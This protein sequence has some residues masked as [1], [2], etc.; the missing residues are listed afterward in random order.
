MPAHSLLF[1]PSRDVAARPLVG[2]PI[3]RLVSESVQALREKRLHPGAVDVGPPPALDG[4]GVAPV[5]KQQAQ[6]LVLGQT[7][8]P[9]RPGVAVPRPA[10]PALPAQP[11]VPTPAQPGLERVVD[12]A[13]VVPGP[14]VPGPLLVPL[15]PLPPPPLPRL[16]QA[17]V[18]L[19][20]H[21][22]AYV[23]RVLVLGHGLELAAAA[24]AQRV[25][26][27]PV[28]AL[29]VRRALVV[30]HGVE[31]RLAE[32]RVRVKRRASEWVFGLGV[33]R[34]FFFPVAPSSP[35]P[36]PVAPATRLF[37]AV[38]VTSAASVPA[39]VFFVAASAGRPV[40]ARNLLG[41]LPEYESFMSLLNDCTSSSASASRDVRSDGCG[42]C[43]RVRFGDAREA[44]WGN[45]G[46]SVWYGFIEERMRARLDG[47]SEGS[48][49]MTS[50]LHEQN[51]DL[52]LIHFG[53]SHLCPPD[54][55]ANDTPELAK[56][57]ALEDGLAHL[58]A[59]VSGSLELLLPGGPLSDRQLLPRDRGPALLKGRGVSPAVGLVGSASVPSDDYVR[60]K[61]YP[62]LALAL[63]EHHG[64]VGLG[65]PL[66]EGSSLAA[67]LATR[68][69]A[70][71]NF[72]T[73]RMGLSV[74]WRISRKL[75]MMMASS[76]TPTPK[77]VN[78]V[79]GDGAFEGAATT[80]RAGCFGLMGFEAR[81]APLVD[82]VT[83]SDP[84]VANFFSGMVCTTAVF[85]TE[86]EASLTTGGRRAEE[87]GPAGVV[88]AAAAAAALAD[89]VDFGGEVLDVMRPAEVGTGG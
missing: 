72:L 74:K 34:F 49:I 58:L 20:P 3:C 60:C 52:V 67:A 31:Q 65:Q 61:F 46:P 4:P 48:C 59:P 71:A 78:T 64:P 69:L 29:P 56:E 6:R 8:V 22:G 21:L 15:R 27:L 79:L 55:I 50:R 36:V 85:A 11:P 76:K 28:H 9:A 43:G 13:G 77:M 82:V 33:W 73:P 30:R 16:Q 41:L 54:K 38:V 42:S 88:V 17:R 10:L 66:Q 26:R 63:A 39:I 18:R 70:G 7:L 47:L 19:L 24:A 1:Q 51:K 81:R 32:R 14:P 89:L 86:T 83:F 2:L 44:L 75:C 57:H 84:G 45:C 5:R 40:P 25:D 80:Y 87:P 12:P 23:R 68:Q 53:Q 62:A 37:L 35:V